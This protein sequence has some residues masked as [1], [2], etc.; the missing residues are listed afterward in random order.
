MPEISIVRKGRLKTN[1]VRPSVVERSRAIAASGMLRATNIDRASK[2][3]RRPSGDQNDGNEYTIRSVLCSFSDRFIV[4]PSEQVAWRLCELGG[5]FDVK[6]N[7]VASPKPERDHYHPAPRASLD[8]PRHLADKA[9]GQG[10]AVD[11]QCGD[12]RHGFQRSRL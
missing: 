1:A 7:C 8:L 11:G 4:A 5:A 6:A 2:R 9:T 12:P 10:S 3:M